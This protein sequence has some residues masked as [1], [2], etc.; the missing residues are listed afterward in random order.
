M[1]EKFRGNLSFGYQNFPLSSKFL[2][3]T[4]LSAILKFPLII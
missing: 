2:K 4:D 3:P 1:L